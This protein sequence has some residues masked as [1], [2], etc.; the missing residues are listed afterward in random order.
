MAKKI[1]EIEVT[2]KHTIEVDEDNSVVKEYDT[3]QEL[4]E[5]LVGYGFAPILPVIGNGAVKVKES[6]TIEHS[7]KVIS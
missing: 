7:Y 6:D 5:D 1:I 3:V 2:T 4:V